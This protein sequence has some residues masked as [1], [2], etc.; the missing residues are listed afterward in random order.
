LE[1]LRSRAGVADSAIG[2]LGINRLAADLAR[3]GGGHYRRDAEAIQRSISQ[4]EAL[5]KDLEGE[6]Q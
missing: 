4:N 5:I 2:G 6:N 1:I 3:F